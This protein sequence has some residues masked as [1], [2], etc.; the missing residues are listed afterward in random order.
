MIGKRLI[1]RVVFSVCQ[2]RTTFNPDATSTV[3]F[4]PFVKILWVSALSSAFIGLLML[5]VPVEITGEEA[6]DNL[7]ITRL[8][9]PLAWGLQ[10]FVVEGVAFMLLQKGCGMG[11]GRKAF[12][13]SLSWAVVTFVMQC[14]VYSASSHSTSVIFQ[15][16]YAANDSWPPAPLITYSLCRPCGARCCCASS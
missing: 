16:I 9:Y 8:L 3:I 6:H 4:P 15:V 12:R 14:G 7:Q 11:A 2:A 5:L 1:K 13:M 10:H